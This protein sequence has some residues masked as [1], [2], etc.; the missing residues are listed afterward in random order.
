MKIENIKKPED[1]LSWMKSLGYATFE[2]KNWDL[3]IVG[4]RKHKG[5][6]NK[7][8]DKIF[9]VCKDDT[10][11][12][13]M[14]SWTATTDPGLYWMENTM[15]TKGCAALVP[16]QYRGCW[17][18]GLHSGKEA[19][20]QI[21]PVKVYRDNNKDN[22]LDLDPKSITEGVYGINLHRA[23][24]QSTSVDKWSAGCQVWA[25]NKDFEEFLYLCKRQVAVNGFRHFSYTLL[26]E[27]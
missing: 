18:L 27:S 13:K 2:N 1:L 8:D 11:T 15:N 23:G 20:R 22:V 26:D 17:E 5:S 3:N 6:V 24:R 10:G 4:V 12:L 9:V 25:M 7:F 19:L 16:G 21:K 14:W